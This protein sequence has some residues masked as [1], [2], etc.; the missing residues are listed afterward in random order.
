MCAAQKV[1]C[2]STTGYPDIRQTRLS[3]VSRSMVVTNI[4][5]TTMTVTVKCRTSVKRVG[6]AVLL[7]LLSLFDANTCTLFIILYVVLQHYPRTTSIKP[8]KIK[9]FINITN[10]LE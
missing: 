4:S 5:G 3:S 1:T 8:I 7:L 6:G 9:A 2:R 10:L